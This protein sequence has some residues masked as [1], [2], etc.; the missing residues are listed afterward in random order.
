[1]DAGRGANSPAR[2]LYW[3]AEVVRGNIMSKDSFKAKAYL[4]VGC[5]FSFKFLLFM[6]EA[7]LLDQIETIRCDPQDPDFESIKAKLAAGLNKP[8]TFPT[9]EVEPGRYRSDSDRLIEYYAQKNNVAADK[10]P[11][12]AF[13]K[14]SIFPQV[15][16]LH[17]KE[18]D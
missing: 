13:Y 12:L 8:A 7:R 9:V 10:L 2:A 1:M 16:E 17:E 18:K 11:A 15:V 4:K 14:E 3:R 6:A 5:P